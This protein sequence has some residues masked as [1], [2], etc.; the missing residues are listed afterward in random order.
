[1]HRSGTSLLGGLLEKLGVIFPGEKFGP[2]IHNPEGYFEWKEIVDLQERLLID[3]DRWWPSYKGCLPLPKGWLERTA[4]KKV[5]LRIIELLSA[6]LASNKIIAIKDPRSSRLLPLWLLIADK[7]KIPIKIILSVRDPSEVAISLVNRDA[8]VTGMNYTRAQQLWFRHNFEVIDYCSSSIPL[9]VVDYS[10]WFSEPEKQLEHIIQSYDELNPSKFEIRHALSFIKKDLRRSYNK[11][12]NL[13]RSTKTLYDLLVSS[14]FSRKRLESISLSP[15]FF[16]ISSSDSP[17]REFLENF[18]ETWSLWIKKWIYHPAPTFTDNLSV[19]DCI[20]LQV[21]GA[22]TLDWESH[23][24]IDKLPIKIQSNVENPIKFSFGR[25][26]FVKPMYESKA[27][28]NKLKIALNLTLPSLEESNLWLKN[29]RTYNVI[30]DPNPSHIYLLRALGC[31]AFWIDPS[32]ASNGWLLDG[33]AV[34]P[35]KW[36]S[37]LGLP[38]PAD[39]HLIVCGHL[40]SDWDSSFA[41]EANYCSDSSKLP[42]SY[43]P[44]WFDLSLTTAESS[45]ALAGWILYAS[46]HCTRFIVSDQQCNPLSRQIFSDVLPYSINS[47]SINTPCSPAELRAEVYGKQFRALA[48]ERPS[49]NTLDVF[50]WTNNQKPL[51]SILVSLYNY[52][53]YILDALQGAA[54]QTQ[55]Q[56][57]LIVVD[58]CSK[59]KGLFLVR[60][61]MSDLIKAESHPF[62]SVRLVKHLT[63]SGLSVSRNTAFGLAGSDWCFVLDADNLLLKDA[64]SFCLSCTSEATEKLAVVHPLIKVSAD[65]SR[66]DDVRSLVGGASWQREGFLSHNFIDAMALVRKSAWKHVGGYTHIEGGWEDYDFW[67]KLIE[68]GFFGIQCPSI[69][70]IYRSHSTSMSHIATNRSWKALEKTLAERHHWLDL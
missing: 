16:S 67:C 40:G 6:E 1:M 63:N 8:H 13:R 66:L 9:T 22:S 23:I 31:N 24:W 62:V 27:S 46:T 2:D 30:F 42:I 61:W 51:A 50:R 32:S 20:H 7:L 64:L 56:I 54:E 3:L 68:A 45:L 47:L 44:G 10:K 26:T 21:F 65:N 34:N 43:F 19:N 28:E 15:Y 37:L 35:S 29:L 38:T 41:Q 14:D 11:K 18:P 33:V 17:P 49:P 58:D 48:E 52:E 36:A 69:Q 53:E 55:N 12:V 39:R 4:T 70:A 59:D 25:I 57:E 5:R 60:D